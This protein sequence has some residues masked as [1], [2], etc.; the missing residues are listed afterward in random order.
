M[1]NKPC[2]ECPWRKDSIP[3][4]LG[5]STPLEFLQLNE[6][7]QHMPCHLTVDYES[8]DWEELVQDAPACAG[9]LVHLKNRCKQPMDPSLAEAMKGV[10]ADHDKI[11]FD[12]SEFFRHHGGKG[13][14]M[15]VGSLVMPT[16]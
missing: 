16:E 14:I 4:W 3:G 6:S 11:F 5:D 1:C 13:G 2:K 9:R 12:P 15:I 8:D 7:E 10:E